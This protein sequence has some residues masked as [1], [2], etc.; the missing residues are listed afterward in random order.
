MPDEERPEDPRERPSS[1]SGIDDRIER[2]E[3]Y[4][5]R[6]KRNGS[7]LFW[8]KYNPKSEY[9]FDLED[10]RED[11]EWM[12]AEIKHLREENGKLREFIDSLRA[13]MEK[14]LGMFG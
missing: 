13:Q 3:K 11:V 8:F 1:H 7:Q 9:K 10:A 6:K 12:L 14:E 4:F 2:I 5:A